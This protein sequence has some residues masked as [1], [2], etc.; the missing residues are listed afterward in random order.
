MLVINKIEWKAPLLL[1]TAKDAAIS[2]LCCV[3]PAPDQP[4]LGRPRVHL[5]G[6]GGAGSEGQ[7][8][9]SA[10]QQGQGTQ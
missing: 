3:S 2:P 9:R 4:D 10:G 8:A 5:D 1:I 7:A 6:G